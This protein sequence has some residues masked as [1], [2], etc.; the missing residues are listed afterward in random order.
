VKLNDLIDI[1]WTKNITVHDQATDKL[2]DF[3]NNGFGNANTIKRVCNVYGNR[4]VSM[5]WPSGTATCYIEIA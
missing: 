3:D 4:T 1:I 5:I 2:E